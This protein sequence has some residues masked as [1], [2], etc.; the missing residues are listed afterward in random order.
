VKQFPIGREAQM[1]EIAAAVMWLLSDESS[2]VV[3]TIMDVSGGFA[4]R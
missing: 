2:Y 4:I 3:G 1:N